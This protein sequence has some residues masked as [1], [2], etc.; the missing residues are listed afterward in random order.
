MSPSSA[1]LQAIRDAPHVSVSSIKTFLACPMKHAH[2]YR[3]GTEPSHR[4]VA[5]VLGS[6][7]HEALAAF[8]EHLRSGKGDPPHDLLLSVFSDAW[9]REV[10][11]Q[12]PVLSDDLDAERDAG[13]ALLEAFHARAVR[14]DRVL[15]VEL[16]F[17]IPITGPKNGEEKE[18][19]LVGAI[20]A[21][22][23]KDGRIIVIENKTAKRRWAEEQL[24]FDIQLS[25]YKSA[26]RRLGLASDPGLQLHFLLKQ[27]KPVFEVEEVTRTAAQEAEALL[28]V[29]QVLKAVEAG[30][31]FP[32]RG[33]MCQDCEYSHRCG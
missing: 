27:K 1:L 16:P 22:V 3:L 24:R 7:V 12:P 18:A 4:A 6:T 32:V 2:R 9:R 15:G 19:L 23:E 25:V 21:I 11:A 17:A 33:W 8:Y 26:L 10:A 20:D 13:L 5:L 29:D 31:A 14:P 30:I 28:V